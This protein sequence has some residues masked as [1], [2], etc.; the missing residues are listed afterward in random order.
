MK[1]NKQKPTNKDI[2][3]QIHYLSYQSNEHDNILKEIYY[4]IDNYIE[5]KGDVKD[6]Q[7]YLKKKKEGTSNDT[8]RKQPGGIE[9]IKK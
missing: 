4:L 1:K 7:A 5:M 8:T 6:F 9:I 3:Q 2:T